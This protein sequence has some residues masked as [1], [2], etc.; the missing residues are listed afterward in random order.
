[1][2]KRRKEIRYNLPFLCDSEE[3]SE[4]DSVA[5]ALS[6]S[7]VPVFLILQINPFRQAEVTLQLRVSLSDLVLSFLTGPTWLVGGVRNFFFRRD[8]NP[9]TATLALALSVLFFI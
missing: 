5:F 6:F 3:G 8:L 4:P 2:P 7:V 9:F 1:V